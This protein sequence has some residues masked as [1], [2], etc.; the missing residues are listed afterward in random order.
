M[1]CVCVWARACADNKILAV[2]QMADPLTALMY[3]VQVMNFLK[4][5]IMKTLREREDSRA[6]TAPVCIDLSDDSGH[7]SPS[8][9]SLANYINDTSKETENIYS[10][11][12]L[13]DDEPNADSPHDTIP[14]DTEESDDSP[15]QLITY[16]EIT[17]CF[18]IGFC[19]GMIVP[20]SCESDIMKEALV[21]TEQM[22]PRST[23]KDKNMSNLSRISSRMEHTEAWR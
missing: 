9:P 18:Q 4:T 12:G 20:Q 6:N 15:F 11:C 10:E 16:K 1:L 17:S 23:E 21:N 22:V 7:E 8:P 14:Y 13:T 19:E 2:L 5:L 3:A